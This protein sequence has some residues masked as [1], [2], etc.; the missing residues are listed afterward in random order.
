MRLSQELNLL[1]VD[2]KR[3][4]RCRFWLVCSRWWRV[5]LCVVG[6]PGILILGISQMERV[7]A[8]PVKVGGPSDPWMVSLTAIIGIASIFL[9]AWIDR[10]ALL[11]I[12][13]PLREA[14]TSE[15]IEAAAS[16]ELHAHEAA[17][18]EL[19][20]RARSGDRKAMDYLLGRNRSRE[21]NQTGKNIKRS[22]PW[23][24]WFPTLAPKPTLLWSQ[25]LGFVT[26]K[27]EKARPRLMCRYGAVFAVLA[28]VILKG[29]EELFEGRSRFAENTLF[30][31]S[32]LGFTAAMWL[33][34]AHSL[35]IG[36]LGKV[37]VRQLAF[38]YIRGSESVS[39]AAQKELRG[40]AD[41]D[42]LALQI[43]FRLG[44]LTRSVR[45]DASYSMPG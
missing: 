8:P 20:A 27:D 21:N 41:S 11:L 7:F 33:W 31:A 14:L 10:L 5:R 36:A 2:G 19:L 22:T 43:C 15:V 1:V 16:W 45:E 34:S 6:F 26:I 17:A 37:S 18:Q 40:R 29:V 24:E 4:D 23:K 28:A 38:A 32:L 42:E 39:Q 12:K 30:A 9:I 44:L 13:Q 25:E 35:S 3:L